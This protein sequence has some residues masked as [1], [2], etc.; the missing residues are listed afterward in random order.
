MKYREKHNFIKK[1]QRKCKHILSLTTNRTLAKNHVRKKIK[2][3]FKKI[4][5]RCMPKYTNTGDE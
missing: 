4:Q 3:E 2:A 1:T 5:C